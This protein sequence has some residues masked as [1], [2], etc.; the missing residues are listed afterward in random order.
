MSTKHW[1]G[2]S[3]LSS[4][5]ASSAHQGTRHPNA[6]LN[7]N[8]NYSYSAVWG[9]RNPLGSLIRTVLVIYLRSFMKKQGY[10]D[11]DMLEGFTSGMRGLAVYSVAAGLMQ[12]SAADDHANKIAKQKR[13]NVEKHIENLR[14][15]IKMYHEENLT[16]DEFQ[17]KMVRLPTD[18]AYNLDRRT[19][20]IYLIQCAIGT[21]LPSARPHLVRALLAM[22]HDVPLSQSNFQLEHIMPKVLSAVF[23]TEVPEE[24]SLIPQAFLA[25]PRGEA[26]KTWL[27]NYPRE[28]HEFFL[29]KFGNL[30]LLM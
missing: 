21:D 22:H 17:E 20:A 16:Y 6:H 12:H 2:C 10:S 23:T 29:D 7:T 5:G 27:L 11:D 30:T 4:Y 14:G 13:N 1:I 25:H 19:P 3:G 15:M 9:T 26:Q 18:Q 28:L 24:S 8:T